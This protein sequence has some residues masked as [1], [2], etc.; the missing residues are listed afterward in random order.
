VSATSQGLMEV[1]KTLAVLH[2]DRDIVEVRTKWA[3]GG[4]MVGRTRSHETIA[5]W[6][7]FCG[8]EPSIFIT[9][10]QLPPGL[11]E[12]PLNSSVFDVGGGVK[13]E[14]VSTIR[15]LVVDVDARREDSHKPATEAQIAEARGRASAIIRWLDIYAFPKPVIADSGNGVHLLYKA[16]L[17]NQSV[18]TPFL[19]RG[20]TKVLHEKFDTDKQSHGASQVLR[21]YGAVNPKGGR[22]AAIT[23]I[24][25]LLEELREDMLKPLLSAR[26][27]LW[28]PRKK[29]KD[30]V[31]KLG[32]F[33]EHC[34]I[35][36]EECG[37]AQ[38]SKYVMAECPLCGYRKPGVAVAGKLAGG[39]YW[40]RCFHEPT[41][42]GARWPEFREAMEAE[43]GK[44]EFFSTKKEIEVEDV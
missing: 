8:G 22:M 12:S 33:L 34:G 7:S 4:T 15:W 6:A 35:D 28:K 30:S 18:T 20:F 11:V 1:L 29:E 43:H 10:N 32:E 25:E 26:G 17:D 36:A 3:S 24:P 14:Y 27:I 31:D 23:H 39:G 40:F 44:F 9:I 42:G 38:G 13:N 41:C 2:P 19:I 16:F 21:L 37:D 5:E